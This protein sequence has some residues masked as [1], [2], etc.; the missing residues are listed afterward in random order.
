MADRVY[1]GP[2]D[3]NSGLQT[4]YKSMVIPEQAFAQLNDTYV[5]RGRVRKRPGIQ[6][7]GNTSLSSRLR[8]DV[9]TLAAPVSP[10]PLG[11]GSIGQMFSIADVVFTVN[12]LGAPAV[13]LVANGSATTKTFDTNTGAFSFVG[14]LDSLGVAVPLGTTIYWYP[15]LPV[16]GLIQNET[17]ALN[18]E[19]TIAFDTRFAYQYVGSG[20]ERIAAEAAAG[21]AEWTGSN[22]QFFQ[23]VTWSG[24]EPYD[25]IFFVTNFNETEPNFLR[26][27][28]SGIWNSFRPKVSNLV[29]TTVNDIWLDSCRMFVV[30]KNRL[31][32]LNTW[33]TS[34]NGGGGGPTQNQYPN[35]ARYSQ[36][37]SPLAADAWRQDIEGRGNA[38]DAPT[39]E[40]IVG[41]QFVKDRLIVY[42]E[43]STWELVYT[44]NVAYPFAWQQ[45]N[46]EIGAESTFSLVPFDRVVLG[47]GQNGIHAC[48]GANVERIDTLIPNL[49]FTIHNANNGI[50][51]VYGIRDFTTEVVYWSF[52]PVNSSTD[53]PFPN[54][55]ICYN[56]LTQTW[57]LFFESTTCLGY[58]QPT[59][60]VLWSSTTVFWSDP[61]TW[62]SARNQSDFRKVIGGNQ[63]GF[64]YIIA[65][66]ASTKNGVIQITDVTFVAGTIQ[67]TAVNHNFAEG[68]YVRISGIYGDVNIATLNDKIGI[69]VSVLSANAFTLGLLPTQSPPTTGT[70]TGGGV[71]AL[72]SYPQVK[73]KEFNFYAD[74]GQNTYVSR[75][76]FSVDK[77]QAGAI[78]ADYFISSNPASMVLDGIAT[79]TQ[80]GTNILETSPYTSI[81]FET[82]QIRLWHTLYF[83]GDG[84]YFQL[85]LYLSDAQM[86]N[87]VID[88]SDFQLHAMILHATPT[89]T[90]LQ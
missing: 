65:T 40:Q 10:V 13:M 57:S 34:D 72:V 87:I 70:Y 50:E 47:I 74:K 45:I 63:E 12:A 25:Y 44:G 1:I 85:Y 18:S 69:V 23:G 73:T 68:Q 48:N 71:M 90:R 2:F 84:E 60:S 32:A 5:Y 8:V 54:Q 53:F 64:T 35:R 26:Y 3:K 27:L 42:F 37:G 41:A 11:A 89:S 36:V 19:P 31:V 22:S 86:R 38:I 6:W 77:T 9:G 88:H 67:I 75:I 62:G 39:R 16:M 58:F 21:D 52:S 78:T 61:L 56:Y 83:L 51:R 20:W 14:V 55:M 17:T 7:L 46:T 28:S 59:N 80:L 49:V 15:A 81:P 29:G 33:E 66:D 76:D 30:F 24:V 79:G 4:N 43:R 82:G